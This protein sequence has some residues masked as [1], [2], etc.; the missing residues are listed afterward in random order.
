MATLKAL[1]FSTNHVSD[2]ASL[3]LSEMAQPVGAAIGEPS[4]GSFR[5]AQSS[6]H[7]SSKEPP[8]SKKILLVAAAFAL[9][10]AACGDDDVPADLPAPAATDA[11]APTPTTAAPSPAAAPTTAAPPAESDGPTVQV[12]A[13]GLGDIVTD[14]EGNTLYLFFP[15]NQGPSAC[16][17]GC[18][19]A[20]PPLE[21]EPVAGDGAT[22][23][24]TVTRD[25]GTTQ[26]TY[27]GWPLYYFSADS[28]P[29]DTNGQTI[30]NVWRVISS[31]GDA[32][33]DMADAT[34][35]PTVQVAASG[36]GDIVTDG[37]GNT[38]YLFFPDNQGPSACNDGCA[39]AW[40]P[41]EGEP[42]AGDGATL[43]GT[44]TRDDGTTQATYNGWPLYY[45]SADSTPGDTN[46]QTIDNVWRVI[47]SAGDAII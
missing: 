15:D 39:A 9:V 11:P 20:W 12:A 18:A 44:V 5:I 32:I 7:R 16:N 45:F 28:T 14:G 25:D 29:G 40:P 10:A 36:L 41:L 47:S 23:L 21:G 19:A 33:M 4:P 3:D 17:D 26:A 1:V 2:V 31:A 30:D 38:L 8:M 37:E 42:V 24:G 46:G 35:G 6:A 22:L 43:L 34:D 13:S 27:N